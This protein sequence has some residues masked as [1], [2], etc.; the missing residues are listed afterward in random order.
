MREC[1]SIFRSVIRRQRKKQQIFCRVIRNNIK[2]YK[3]HG[4]HYSYEVDRHNFENS[5]SI[6]LFYYVRLYSRILLTD[7]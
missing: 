1:S 6:R 7:L 2:C 5:T 4:N 3:R